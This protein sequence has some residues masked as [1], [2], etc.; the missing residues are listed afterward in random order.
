MANLPMPDQTKTR[1]HFIGLFN[2]FKALIKCGPRYT[3]RLSIFR[4]SPS[5][6]GSYIQVEKRK[7]II[8][9]HKRKYYA[10]IKMEPPKSVKRNADHLVEWLTF[11]HNF[12]KY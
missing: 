1:K 5:V 6:C 11:C 10:I 2:L 12:I 9:T 8:H 4:R 3:P 7:A